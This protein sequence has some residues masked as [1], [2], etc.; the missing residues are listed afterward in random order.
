LRPE[1]ARLLPGNMVA[2]A[3]VMANPQPFDK[4]ALWGAYANGQY[5]SFWGNF[6]WLSIPL[7]DNLYAVM[8]IICVLALAGLAVGSVA[9][10]RGPGA[11]KGRGPQPLASSPR[12]VGWLGFVALFS[13]VATM[14]VSYAWQTMLLAT[15]FQPALLSGRYLFVLIIPIAWLLLAGLDAVSSFLRSLLRRSTEYRVTRPATHHSVL[16][17]RYSVLS[18]ATLP[19]AVWLYSTGLILFAAYC[20]LTLILPNYY[21]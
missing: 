2:V 1:L 3:D 15:Q 5:T 4:L 14:V 21:A 20:L 18:E 9:R 16:G 7:P 11:S 10:G 12:F 13:L 17:T 8:A 6:G 19:W